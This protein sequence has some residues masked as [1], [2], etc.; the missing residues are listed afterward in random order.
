MGEVRAKDSGKADIGH[1]IPY[2]GGGSGRDLRNLVPLFRN[3]NQYDMN[4]EVESYVRK[5]LKAKNRVIVSVRPFYD[6]A[7]SGVPAY[8]DYSFTS[9]TPSGAISKTMTCKIINQQARGG[10]TC[11]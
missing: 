8:L 3:T 9:F 6:D 10:T 4:W 2:A 11:S 1:L 7:S 5:E